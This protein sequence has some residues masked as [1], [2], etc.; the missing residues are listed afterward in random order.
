MVKAVGPDVND[1]SIGDRVVVLA[2]N[3]F[4]TTER[5]PAWGCLKMLPE[6]DF[7]V[8]ER[9]M[10]KVATYQNL[11]ILSSAFPSF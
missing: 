1:L 5:V 9:A 2:P 11:G 3:S 7:E 10:L 4:R 8:S 6:E